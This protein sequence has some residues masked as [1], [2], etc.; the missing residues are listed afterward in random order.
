MQRRPGVRVAEEEPA[1]VPQRYLLTIV[2]PARHLQMI[3]E[4]ADEVLRLPQLP[5]ELVRPERIEAL[6]ER[7]CERRLPGRLRSDEHDLLDQRRVDE[8]VH[9]AAMPVEV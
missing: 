7:T 3:G 2:L 5:A 6:R 4:R 1:S 9:P 8:R